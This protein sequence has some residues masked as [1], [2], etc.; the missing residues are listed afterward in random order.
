MDTQ[1][2]SPLVA[3]NRALSRWW[4]VVLCMLTGGL[5]GW[6]FHMVNPPIYESMATI[7]VNIDFLKVDLTQY[8]EDYAINVAQA[9]A[10]SASV[11]DLVFSEAQDSGSSVRPEQVQMS[12]EVK[13]SIWEFHVRANDPAVASKL[14][15]I[16]SD[17]AY[18]ILIQGRDHALRAEQLQIELSSL[19]NCF[20]IGDVSS[21]SI[22][23]YLWPDC[24]LYTLAK[25]KSVLE[26]N[27]SQYK[28]E[29]AL[30]QGISS[31]LII[32]QLEPAIASD[33]P[34]EYH[35]ATLVLAG[36]FIGFVISLLIVNIRK[37][38]RN[39]EVS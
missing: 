18:A 32:N 17:T 36:A 26:Q 39:A 3:V 19:A 14:A 37:E 16:W 35:Q 24:K 21:E 12:L 8:E 6:G 20:S 9:V 31:F 38:K 5:M 33:A 30:S 34:I 29:Q 27:F 25:I 10:I 11:K 2:F 4:I 22:P 23:S 7:T 28:T 1:D 13:Q 15:N